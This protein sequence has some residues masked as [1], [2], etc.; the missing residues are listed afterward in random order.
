M[1]SRLNAGRAEDF[2]FNTFNIAFMLILITVTLYPFLN[3]IA[4]S[5]NNGLDTIRGGIYLWPRMFTLQNYKAV[6]ITGTVFNAFLISV[7]RTVLSTVLNIFLTT[8]LSYTLSRKEYVLRKPITVLFVLTM[9]FNAG[10]IPNYFLIKGLGLTNNFLV[11]V[12]PTLI[13]AF[14]MIVIRTYIKTIPESLVESS[15]IDGAGDFR[16]FIQ[17][18]FPLCKPVLATVALFVAVGSWNTWFDTYIYCSSKQELS[19]LQY[20]LM[21]LLA[22]TAN[23]NSNPAMAAGIGASSQTSQNMV[24]PVSIRAAIT[25][26]AAVPILVVYPFLQKYFV[27][28]LNVGSVKE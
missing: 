10:L 9:Y 16:I 27:V 13:A 14:N 18:I 4:V 23:T 2:I 8:M 15:R 11:Y 26:V 24:T 25:I 17:V 6:F 5:F 28:G 12:V 19:T 22:S 3:T 21:K 20:E 7:A 1:K